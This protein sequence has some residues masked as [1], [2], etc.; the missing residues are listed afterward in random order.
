MSV[1]V[2]PVLPILAAAFLLSSCSV[3]PAAL[4][5]LRQVLPPDALHQ[6]LRG[7]YAANQRE[8]DTSEPIGAVIVPHHLASPEAIAVGIRALAVHPPARIVLLTPDHFATCG[9]LLCTTQRSFES[10]LGPVPTDARAVSALLHSALVS[11]QDALFKREHG[12]GVLL[13]FLAHALPE[14]TVLPLALAQRG[15][16]AQREQ[17]AALILDTVGPQDA[18]VVSSDFSHYLPLAEADAADAHTIEVLLSGDLPAIAELPNP[19]HSDCPGCLWLLT[20]LAQE[21]GLQSGKV[22]MHTNAARLLGEPDAAE[23]TGHFTII[24]ERSERITPPPT[25]ASRR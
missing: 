17:L 11:E 18:L 1:R 7:I 20:V 25:P 24:W 15:W 22:L 13:P 12:I 8:E 9:T 4:P 5:P 6:I 19:S 16:H 3:A 21:R 23:T 10:L 2:R 14:T